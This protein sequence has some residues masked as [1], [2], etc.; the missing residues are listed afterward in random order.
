M[1]DTYCCDQRAATAGRE[2]EAGCEHGAHTPDGQMACHDCG[3]P[4]HY[5]RALEDYRHST[6][7]ERGCF[8][9]GADHG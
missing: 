6:A 8:L 9:I 1:T 4:I 7:P 3:R 2:C 5:D